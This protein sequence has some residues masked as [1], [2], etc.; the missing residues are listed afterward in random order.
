MGIRLS[1]FL[2]LLLKLPG[3]RH[4]ETRFL[5]A[6]NEIGQDQTDKIQKEFQRGK[7]RRALSQKREW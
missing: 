1:D 2:V 5:P 3:S 7:A 6:E 4:Q